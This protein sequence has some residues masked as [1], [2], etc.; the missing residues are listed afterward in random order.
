MVRAVVGGREFDLTKDDVIRSMRDVQPE[1]IREHFVVI[2]ERPF[3]PKQALAQVTGWDRQT[4]TTMEAIRVL[5][6]IGFTCQRRVDGR[7]V[8][9][10]ADPE[11]LREHPEDSRQ[12]P[13]SPADRRLSAMESA[14]TVIQE[15][16]AGLAQR[17]HELE[18]K[19]RA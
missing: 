19:G 16:I 1:P 2:G 10:P 17:V 9:D 14:I 15:A 4:F 6:R 11:D 3:P 18:R 7:P 13:A 8:R 5:T 12:Q